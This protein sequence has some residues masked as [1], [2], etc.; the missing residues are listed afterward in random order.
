MRFIITALTFVGEI[1]S[2]GFSRNS[3]FQTISFHQMKN[4]Y[5]DHYSLHSSYTFKK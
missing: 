4:N 2:D 1:L 3:S 5:F